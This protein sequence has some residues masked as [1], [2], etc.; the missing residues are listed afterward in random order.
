M[1]LDDIW[2]LLGYTSWRRAQAASLKEDIVFEVFC[3]LYW[4]YYFYNHPGFQLGSSEQ[5]KNNNS[6]CG[7][8]R[9]VKTWISLKHIAYGEWD[10]LSVKWPKI[11]RK[12]ELCFKR[13]LNRTR[14]D[15]VSSSR[16]ETQWH[17]PREGKRPSDKAKVNLPGQF[18]RIRP[19]GSPRE[20]SDRPPAD[21]R[22]GRHLRPAP[23][24]KG[25]QRLR[26][27]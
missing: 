13:G 10:P 26:K 15:T 4:E 12:W 1:R 7:Y 2:H 18:A 8:L 3:F 23:Q 9:D 21:R 16:L 14:C 27:Q 5:K 22:G 19:N 6:N 17:I 11:P 25:P 20:L 24:D